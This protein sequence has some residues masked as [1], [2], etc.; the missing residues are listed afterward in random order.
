M[1]CLFCQ[2]AEGEKESYKVYEDERTFAFLDVNPASRGHTLVIP[3]K[4]AVTIFD[5]GEE[6]LRSV[7][8]TVKKI[9]G[10][11]NEAFNPRGVNIIQSNGSGAGQEIEHFH[12]HVVPRYEEDDI[13]LDFNQ[14][15][16]E[17]PEDTLELLTS[18]F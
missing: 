18:H 9:S 17:D 1:S 10:G 2:I 11:I 16:L 4:H 12:V 8:N 5:I 13:I 15:T 3:K 7:M 14:D 6:E